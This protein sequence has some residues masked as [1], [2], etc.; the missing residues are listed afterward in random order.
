MYRKTKFRRLAVA[1]AA[2]AVATA[3]AFAAAADD[4][5]IT[6][7]TKGPDC[8]R[9]GTTVLDGECYALVW[10]ADGV[11]DGFSA[12][13]ST[14]DASDR[15]VSIGNV[16]K[17]GCCAV[18][19]HISS[20]TAKELAKGVYSVY[21]LDTRVSEGGKTVPAGLDDSGKIRFLSG[22]GE[23]AAAEVSAAAGETMAKIEEFDFP[24]GGDKQ[25]AT[26]LATA[27]EQAEQ[28]K[29]L[30]LKVLEDKVVLT[31]E[32]KP[33]YIS[34]QSGAD[35]TASDAA[36]P[37]YRVIAD[38]ENSFEIEVP[39]STDGNGAFFRPVFASGR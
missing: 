26:E 1:I 14:L 2:W 4:T 24:A 7:S 23:I 6:F 5:L 28:P 13:G 39:K 17:G 3:A 20:E 18:T 19:Y 38:G 15:V 16:A 33:G 22:Y 32:K 36:T 11:F 21:L 10:S 34:I 25:M 8:Y 27:P 9:D 30:G 29:V 37:A 31:I 12:D 35:T